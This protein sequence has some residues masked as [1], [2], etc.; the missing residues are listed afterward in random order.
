MDDPASTPE[1]IAPTAAESRLAR[2]SSRKLARRL[3]DAARGR[4][5]IHLSSRGDGPDE[6]VAL[7]RPAVRAVIR[8]LAAFADGREVEIVSTPRRDAKRGM[9]ATSDR[10]LTTTQAASLLGVSRPFLIAAMEKGRLPYRKVGTHR[11][12][13]P[14]D[15]MEYKR[16]MERDR[17]QALEDLSA[18]DQELGLGYE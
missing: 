14:A 3:G 15:L 10:E 6:S 8:A 1:R 11:R 7:P 16:S 5:Y 12:V 13:R 4:V 9:K 18:L 2:E 17:V